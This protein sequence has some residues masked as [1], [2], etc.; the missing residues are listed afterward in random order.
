MLEFNAADG[1]HSG[2]LDYDEFRSIWLRY[3]DVKSEL[4][5]RNVVPTSEHR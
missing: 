2:I 5:K 1:D 3:R 4:I